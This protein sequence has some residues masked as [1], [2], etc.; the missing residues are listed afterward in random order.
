[1]R[2]AS[3]R[4]QAGTFL[5]SMM[6]ICAMLMIV[7]RFTSIE[8]GDLVLSVDDGT[9]GILSRFI[10]LAGGIAI[11]VGRNRGNYFAI[12][13]YAMTLGVS[14]LIRS[15]PGLI[16]ESDVTFNISIFIVLLSANLALAGYNHLT[17]KMRNPLNMRYTTI[18]IIAA[19]LIA[20]LYFAY[21]HQSPK[22]IM[23]YLPDT[24]WY[25]PL[26]ISLLIILYSKELVDHS[27]MGRVRYFSG[28]IADRA[29]IGNVIEISEEDAAKI[30]DGFNGSK[31]WNEKTIDGILVH[32][33]KVTFHT[34][35]RDRDVIMERSNDR[36]ELRFTV[37]D[38]RTDSFVNGYRIKASSYTESD[39]KLILRD[40]IG[41]CATLHIRRDV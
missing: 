38:D 4:N 23:E 41:I 10:L 2:E 27:P 24:L 29:H 7:V 20:L 21:T 8:I 11:I 30:R 25:I 40:S 12:G 28:V 1:M 14:R 31:G 32:E 17:V 26:Y 19:Y 36:D 37:I 33:E 3:R 35:K 9:F 22:I 16:D 34:G 6:I 39:D 15:L 5:G 18:A 13:V